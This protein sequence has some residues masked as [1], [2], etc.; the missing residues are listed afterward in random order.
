MA[1]KQHH[2]Q[3]CGVDQEAADVILNSNRQ[4]AR[5]KSHFSVQQRFVS[6]CKERAIDLSAASPAPVVNF[7]AHGRCQ[8]DWSTGTVHT[9][10]SAI[11]EL[12]PDGGTMTKDLTYKEF[13]SALDD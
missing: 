9:Y 8:R 6:W 10:G 1:T 12:F 11:M 2:L 3:A 5:N 7:L 4:R 13:L